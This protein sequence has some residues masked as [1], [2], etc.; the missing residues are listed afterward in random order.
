MH[1]TDSLVQTLGEHGVLGILSDLRWLYV[2]SHAANTKLFSELQLSKSAVNSSKAV[3]KDASFELNS[4]LAWL[5][6]SALTTPA[7]VHVIVNWDRSGC[8]LV[9][10]AGILE[11]LASDGTVGGVKL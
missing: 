4:T 3:S 11:E 5:S 10:L 7:L 8:P 1:T 2:T 6:S 9:C